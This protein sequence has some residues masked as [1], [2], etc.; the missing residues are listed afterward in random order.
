MRPVKLLLLL[1]LL[2]LGL[3]AAPAAR[4][5]TTCSATADS[6][7]PFGTIVSAGAAATGTLNITVTCSTTAISVGGSAGV[8]VCIGLGNGTG[9][10]TT[11]PLRSLVNTTTDTMGFQI[12]NQS[13]YTQIT[14]LTPNTSPA[15][16]QVTLSYT[17]P[18]LVGSG[19]TTTQL[20]AT[21]PA[22]QI[23]A[24]GNYTSNFSGANV[25]LTWAANETLIG[26]IAPPATCTSG[27]AGSFSASSAFNFTASAQVAPLCG[28]YL[29]TDMD[30]GTVN[31]SIT[32][33]IDRTATLTLTCLRRTAYQVSLNNGQN[34][35]G[36]TRRMLNVVNASNQYLPYELYRDTARTQRWGN[37]LAIDTVGGTG[38]GAAQQLTIY[39]RVPPV[40]GQPPAGT[41]NDRIQVTITY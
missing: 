32:G 1:A 29:T 5:I 7:L 22:N 30:F 31:G 20:Y 6:A 37:S 36:S 13:N 18:L 9:G 12:Y 28:S 41:Y 16:K 25:V 3:A 35:Q 10:T 11:S 40:S 33:N 23:L 2:I 21:V 19:T 14:G 39:G 17:A 34:S 24:S 38:N 26:T 8:R 4:A 27:N 15:P